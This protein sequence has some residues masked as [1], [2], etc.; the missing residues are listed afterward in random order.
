MVYE[1]ANVW[2]D[3]VKSGRRE[4]CGVEEGSGNRRNESGVDGSEVICR[5][6]RE[7]CWIGEE[8]TLDWKWREFDWRRKPECDIG[9]CK[10]PRKYWDAIKNGREWKTVKGRWTVMES[11]NR[12]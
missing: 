6:G 1:Y 2:C 8:S 10:L 11:R 9:H 4:R 12:I 7:L 3:E 5:Q